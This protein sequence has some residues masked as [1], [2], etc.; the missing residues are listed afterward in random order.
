M[1]ETSWPSRKY[2][3]DVGRSRQP[4][5]CMNVDLPEPDGPVTA[6][7]SPCSTSRFTPRSA[8]TSI[9]PTTY[10]LTRFLTEMTW[11]IGL[12]ASSAEAAAGTAASLLAKKRIA[13]RSRARARRSGARDARHDLRAFLKIRAVDELRERAVGDPQPD[14]HGLELVAGKH[15]DARVRCVRRERLEE[16]L[17]LVAVL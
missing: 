4:A 11:G 1:R 14:R 15:P 16:F 13:A 7:N 3:P 8:R 9:S 10:R 6:R 5:M 2:W 17:D 12:E